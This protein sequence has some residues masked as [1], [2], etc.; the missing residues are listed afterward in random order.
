LTMEPSGHI[1]HRHPGLFCMSLIDLI[2]VSWRQIVRYRRRYYGVILAITL[3]TAGLQTV[4]LVNR[5]FKKNMNRDLT[6]VG[7]VTVL[8]AYFDNQLTHSP[9]WFQPKTLEALRS[10]P[11]VETVST[12]AFRP[13][14]TSLRQSPIFYFPVIALD[15]AF[16]QVRG[17]WATTGKLFDREAVAGRKREC[18]FGASLAER[19]FGHN[20]IAGLTI[21]IYG[22]PY[23]ITGVL[24]GI[25]DPSL[26]ESAYIPITTVED[27][28]PGQH[29]SDRVYLR[30]R[31]VDDVI[32]VATSIASLVRKYQSTDHLYIEFLA[33]GL[34]RVKQLFWWGEFFSYLTIGLTL[35][36]GGLGIWNVMMA[37]VRSRTREIGLKKAFGAEDADILKEFLTEAVILSLGASC[38]GII[39][40][41]VTVECLS[42]VIDCQ[43]PANLL[44]MCM[45]LELGLGMFLGIVAGLF[46]ARQASRMEVVDAVGYE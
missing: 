35:V 17:F 1:C 19:I 20:N 16:W 27:R 23:R 13:G 14:R 26:A 12:I 38:L 8:K 7:G 34:K 9:M 45:G 4:V 29:L 39:L 15:E 24:G 10:L 6:L 41:W 2:R 11:G 46:P 40:G 37:A 43:P 22:E 25:T 33:E 3:G 18:V 21:D 44:F 31:G 5:D 28:F 36:L 32:P 42:Y 30:C